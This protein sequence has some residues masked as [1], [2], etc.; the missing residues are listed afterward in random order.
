[1]VKKNDS[2]VSPVIA[3]ALSIAGIFFFLYNQIISDIL[4]LISIVF[5]NSSKKGKYR[6]ISYLALL[7]GAVGLILS[8]LSQLTDLSSILRLF[9]NKTTEVLNQSL[10]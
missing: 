5:A 10:S 3:L 1:M 6:L 8:A 2:F 9:E 4:F 7:I